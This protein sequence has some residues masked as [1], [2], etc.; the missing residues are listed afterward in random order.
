LKNRYDSL[1]G[2]VLLGAGIISYLGAF[3]SEFRE[4]CVQDWIAACISD[5]IPSA[6][7][8]SSEQK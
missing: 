8:A 7:L 4:E 3:T 1:T 2:D 6:A 5:R